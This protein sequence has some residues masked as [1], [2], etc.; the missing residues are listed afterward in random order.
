MIPKGYKECATCGVLFKRETGGT[1]GGK[2][3][4]EECK[5]EP[6][7][8][9]Q[10]WKDV[11]DYV[12]RLADCSQD[13]MPMATAQLKRLHTKHNMRYSAIQATLRYVFELSENPPEYSM[14]A[15]V[16]YVVMKNYYQAKEFFS[17]IRRLKRPEEEINEI[18][19]MEPQ[20]IVIN[21][22]D[23]IQEDLDFE[24]RKQKLNYQSMLDMDDIEDITDD[25]DTIDEL[26]SSFDV[27]SSKKGK[28]KIKGELGMDDIED[29]YE[30][31]DCEYDS[32][33]D[34]DYEYD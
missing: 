12:W 2:T 9:Q 17:K 25:E 20:E 16:E 4:C 14:T 26:F 8:Q 24:S 29:D 23:L 30:Y 15:G 6:L 28:K 33:E 21:R 7:K 1:A 18:L 13:H 31:N 11:V 3:Y 5:I 22:S 34:N 27:A 19:S 10:E 32:Y